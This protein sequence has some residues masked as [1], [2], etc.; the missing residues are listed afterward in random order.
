MKRYLQYLLLHSL[1]R[2]VSMGIWLY[3]AIISMCWTGLGWVQNFGL[4]WGCVFRNGLMSNSGVD[5]S[6]HVYCTFARRRFWDFWLSSKCSRAGHSW[7]LLLPYTSSKL[8]SGHVLIFWDCGQFSIYFTFKRREPL[9]LH[10]PNH[11]LTPLIV[12]F[13]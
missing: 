1:N 11:H 12:H 2:W 13:L 4:S 7:N 8:Q 3:Q 5:L 6:G 10:I 9:S